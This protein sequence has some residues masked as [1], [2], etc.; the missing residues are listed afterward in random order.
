VVGGN[1]QQVGFELLLAGAHE[2]G[3]HPMPGCPKCLDLFLHLKGIANWLLPNVERK[4][5][6]EIQTYNSSIHRAVKRKLRPE[7]TLSLKILHRRSY[8]QPI[9]TCEVD[10]LNEMQDKLKKI[11]AQREVWKKSE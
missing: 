1:K 4:S 9:D 3:M 6:Y 11:G 10:C 8:D 7:V 2:E 5:M